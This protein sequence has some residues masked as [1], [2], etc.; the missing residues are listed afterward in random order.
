MTFN[1]S[2]ATLPSVTSKTGIGQ[3]SDF[4]GVWRTLGNTSKHSCFSN[5]D[6]LIQDPAIG[7][8]QDLATDL[9]LSLRLYLTEFGS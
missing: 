2:L 7:R 9:S 5:D 1:G 6:E 8:T 3:V 4:S